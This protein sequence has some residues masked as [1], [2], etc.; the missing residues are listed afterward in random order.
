M[1][2]AMPRDRWTSRGWGGDR[3]NAEG[4]VSDELL[5][6]LP[7]TFLEALRDAERELAPGKKSR[8]AR[9]LQ[10]TANSKDRDDIVKIGRESNKP[11]K[12]VDLVTRA[13]TQVADV[14][15]LASKT[16]LMREAAIR[17]APTDFD[18]IVQTLRTP[19]GEEKPNSGG[20]E[21]TT[22]PS[23]QLDGVNYAGC[24]ARQAAWKRFKEECD[25]SRMGPTGNSP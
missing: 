25:R 14:L 20:G 16:D 13:E 24:A 22:D 17:P 23:G 9:Y 5:Q 3:K 2:L 18:R 19:S 15:N 1:Y 12:A 21:T 11:L 4:T 7:L 10:T 6:A 8:L